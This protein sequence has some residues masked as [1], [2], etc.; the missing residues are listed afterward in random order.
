VRHRRVMRGG[1]TRF[2]RQRSPSQSRHQGTWLAASG[3]SVHLLSPRLRAPEGRADSSPQYAAQGHSAQQ[4]RS[5][6][7]LRRH[8][9][10]HASA[11]LLWCNGLLREGS[12]WARW[13]GSLDGM[14]G[15]RGSNPLSSTP[16]QRPSPPSTTRES[17]RS[18][19]KCAATCCATPIRLSK[20]AVTRATITGVV[21][22]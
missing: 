6:S 19:S 12:W 10:H 2:T 4:P 3:S 15:V 8:T 7:A 5:N 18:R 16:G 20:A 1:R 21:S 14:Q 22:R 17:R 11:L 9:N 13:R